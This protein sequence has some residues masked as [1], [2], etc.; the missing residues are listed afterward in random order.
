MNALVY[1]GGVAL[2]QHSRHSKRFKGKMHHAAAVCVG[3]LNQEVDSSGLITAET[4]VKPWVESKQELK[5]MK[6]L[7]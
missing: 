7:L 1:T 2:V 3:W 5:V 4:A 6:L